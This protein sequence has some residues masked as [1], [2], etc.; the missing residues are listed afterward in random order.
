M[1]VVGQP[2]PSPRMNPCPYVVRVVLLL[3]LLLL[4]VERKV[5]Q[6]VPSPSVKRLGAA[7]HAWTLG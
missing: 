7:V 3:L 6:P 2:V 1:H 5:G 4:V